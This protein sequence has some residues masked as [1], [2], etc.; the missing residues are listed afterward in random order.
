MLITDAGR[1]L[2]TCRCSTKERD[3]KAPGEV[4]PVAV[5]EPDVEADRE[6]E[7]KREEEPETKDAVAPEHKM[8]GKAPVKK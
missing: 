1:L 3:P 6:V 8:V 7:A 4:A 2:P 5:G